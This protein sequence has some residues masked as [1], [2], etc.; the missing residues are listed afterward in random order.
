MWTDGK[1]EIPF[2]W[3]KKKKSFT[4]I[5]KRI[6][7]QKKLNKIKGLNIK[8]DKLDKRP[9]ISINL[10]NEKSEFDKFVSIFDWM[11]NEY[12]K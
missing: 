3:F 7:L 10:L 5:E 1:I 11:L 4:S 9:N 8:D 6:D 2:Q 12:K